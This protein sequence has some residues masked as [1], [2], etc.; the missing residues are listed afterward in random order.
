LASLLVLS[1]SS[2][3]AS[4]ADWITGWTM[5]HQMDLSTKSTMAYDVLLG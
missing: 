3:I 1:T 2:L 4:S 5:M